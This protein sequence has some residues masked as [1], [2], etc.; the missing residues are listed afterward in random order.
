[1][2][3]ARRVRE[4]SR[5]WLCAGIVVGVGACDRMP[6]CRPTPQLAQQARTEV[7]DPVDNWSFAAQTQEIILE[8]AG[9]KGWRPVTI[10][11]AVVDGRFFI[12][13]DDSVEKKVWVSQIVRN[14]QA[15]VTI[16][17]R[18]Y[19]VVAEAITQPALWRAVM[20]AYA[21]KYGGQL[22]KYD[23]PAPDNPSSGKIFELK[24][25]KP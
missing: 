11:S 24:S 17:D 14:P 25:R 2:I 5:L 3:R 15:R 12:A 22:R 4:I 21:S 6:G 1:M 7:A 8:T 13:T 19:P 10:W 9:K 16:G 23:F 20:E 18:V